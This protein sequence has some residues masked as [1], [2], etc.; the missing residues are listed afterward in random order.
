MK[1]L[2]LATLALAPLSAAVHAQSSVTL[3]GSIDSGLRDVGNTT[4]AGGRKLSLGSGT[5]QSNRFGFKGVEDL[6]GGY[7][8][9]FNLE[10][11]FNVGTGALDNT[12]NKIFNRTDKVGIGGPFGSVDLGH[13]YT[14]AH[15]TLAGYEPF[16][17]QYLSIT[18]AGA[19]SA[20]VAGNGRD[21][22]VIRYNGTFDKLK[23]RAAYGVGGVAGSIADGAVRAV[24]FS[25]AIGGL[26]F[27]S[28]Y[29]HKSVSAVAGT[30]PFFGENHYT[31][32]A[33]YKL[34][35]VAAMAGYARDSTA[36][37][38]AHGNTVDRY[39]W[40]GLRY[41]IN[42]FIELIAAYYDDR[43][44]TA[45][46][47]GKKDVAITGVTYLLSKTTFLYADVD[48]THYSGGYVSNLKLNPSGH[49]NQFGMS[50]GINHDF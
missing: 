6:G 27:G 44:T 45:G 41:Q 19:A 25:Y 32:G 24:G 30:P 17:L 26:S 18:L 28:A 9:H 34:G 4:P 8:A 29:T 50:I 14:V 35:P 7:N 48:N 5:Y 3:Y 10:G 33:A 1:K 39:T 38:S 36:T 12:A 13:M 21:D 31:F 20:G 23:L 16:R 43:N 46:I 49:S 22:N 15:D 11:G 42:P 40:G 2:L 37:S 47:D